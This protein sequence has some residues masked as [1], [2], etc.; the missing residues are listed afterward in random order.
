MKRIGPPKGG[1]LYRQVWRSVE[2]AV[3]AAFEAHPEYL[4][5]TAKRRTVI[6]SITKR[7]TGAIVGYAEQS[8]QGR[9]APDRRRSQQDTVS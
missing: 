4:A 1:K 8:A 2:G 3:H 6:N 5:R 7:V 9:S